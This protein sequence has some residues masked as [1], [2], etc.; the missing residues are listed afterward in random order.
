MGGD[1]G[2]SVTVPAV[3]RA[4]SISP[5][6]KFRLFGKKS[7][8]D[9]LIKKNKL[10][11]HSQ[12][13]FISTENVIDS[14]MS[15]SHALRHCKGTSMGEAIFDVAKG[16]S[17]VCISAG[18]T[19]ALMAIAS[20]YLRTVPGI[21]RPALASFLPK[22]NGSTLVLDL[23]ANVS[24]TTENLVQ[25]AYLGV[26]TFKQ[27][28]GEKK[29]SVSLLNVG[30]ESNKGNQVIKKANDI[31]LN[32]E[33][34]NY[35]GYI[36]GDS[37]FNCEADIVVCDGFAGNIALKTAEG[38]FRLIVKTLKNKYY[39]YP[40]LFFL[41]KILLRLRP[42]RYNGACLL[43]LNG[44]VIKSHGGARIKAYTNAIIKASL[45]AN[46]SYNSDFSNLVLSKSIGSN[47]VQ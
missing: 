32:D 27:Y 36:E 26:E 8:C 30:I 37:L 11:N 14:D 20:H 40:I 43:G 24:C 3:K 44:V 21:D 4:L 38:L 28:S 19:G 22:P 18:N 15:P 45:V 39:Y 34:I 33:N 46:I 31:L 13:T 47:N 41:K 23:G 17:S 5:N 35:L 7:L 42:D 25:F 6:L 12:I 9:S 2:P 1:F 29:P 16:N 10:L